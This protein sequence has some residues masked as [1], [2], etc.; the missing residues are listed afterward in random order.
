[1]KKMKLKLLFAIFSA[2]LIAFSSCKKD[3]EEVS[4]IPKL[5]QDFSFTVDANDVTF[6]TTLIGTVFF[7]DHTSGTEHSA[8]DG[9]VIVNI[10][11]AGTYPFTC[12]HVI[13]GENFTS[14]TF[15]VTI[16]VSDL[17]YLDSG[18]W[19]YLTGGRTGQTANP[20]T[21]RM[22]MNADGKCV[23]FAGPM[24]YSGYADGDDRREEWVYWAWDI[25]PDQ[26]PYTVNGQEMTSFFNWE[27]DY[28]GNSWIMAANDYGTITFN[29]VDRTVSTSV[30]GLTES[31]TF[32][33]DPET[34][35]LTINGVTL[36]V[37]TARLN[38][39]QYEETA[40]QNLRIFSLTDTAMQIGIKRMYEGGSLSQWVNVYNFICDDY[41]YE[42]PEEISYVAE[43]KT[44]FT[45]ADLT[46]TWKIADVPMGW[47][48]YHVVGDQ[49]TDVPAHLFEAWDTRA[50]VV[51]TLV[52]WGLSDI[53]SV[54]T[55]NDANTYVFNADGSC[56][57]N[58]VANTFT[59]SGGIITLGT[60]LQETEFNF[61][62]NG[63]GSVHS[64][65]G[66]E[67][68]IIDVNHYGGDVAA[69]TPEG[70]W[71]GQQNETKNEFKAFQL[72]KQ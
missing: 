3:E 16:A 31:G 5:D 48:A 66:T 26:L 63:W 7:T 27:P 38:E 54:F 61:P 42:V 20:K 10:P 19:L 2:V 67:I 1:M 59:V 21:W 64:L 52:S 28:A 72:V 34:W 29:G 15:N 58:G 17:T 11:I 37:D 40:L 60:A 25:L 14:D 68:T 56:T 69:Y 36:P 65:T 32:D 30:F 9:E 53:D 33:L 57:L 49:G 22:D 24:Y 41:E 13:E 46:G 51:G 45:A 62:L 35:K 6:I 39:G 50:D 43:S 71:I 23:Y 8:V 4:K 18:L 47:I 55:A 70:I 44:S 12:T